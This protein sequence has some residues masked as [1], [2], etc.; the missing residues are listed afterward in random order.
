MVLSLLNDISKARDQAAQPSRRQSDSFA[1]PLKHAAARV[2]HSVIRLNLSHYWLVQSSAWVLYFAA[3]FIT[4]TLTS[5]RSLPIGTLHAVLETLAGFFISHLLALTFQHLRTL[6]V[7]IQTP[8]IITLTITGAALWNLFK[9]VTF[10]ALFKD[11]FELPTLSHFGDWYSFS[12]AIFIAWCSAYFAILHYSLLV[13]EREK[14]L[15]LEATTKDAQLKMLRYQLNPH[16]IKNALNAISTLILKEENTKAYATLEK[17]SNFL[18]HTIY[19]DPQELVTLE[20]EIEALDEYMAIEKMR[21]SDQLSIAINYDD[22]ARFCLLPNLILQPLVENAV[23]YGSRGS[24][25]I[26]RIRLSAEVIEKELII[27]ISDNGPGLDLPSP[28]T[29]QRKSLGI[30]LTLD[31]LQAHFGDK[32]NIEFDNLKP[33]GLAVTLSMPACFDTY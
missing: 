7:Y 18:S 8:I 30:S 5:G 4:I 2:W 11:G 1:W 26:T 29:K 28:A 27:V 6:P 16:F 13:T 19:N 24:Q 25:K 23:K 22:D 12:L 31:R 14:S 3:I 9:W 10:N 17:L 32:A 33:V 15:R 21:F 20:N